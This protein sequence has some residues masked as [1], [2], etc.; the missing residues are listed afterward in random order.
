MNTTLSQIININN[1]VQM[2]N[3]NNRIRNQNINNINTNQLYKEKEQNIIIIYHPEK[4]SKDKKTHIKKKSQ[5]LNKKQ[6]I[7]LKENYLNKNKEEYIKILRKFKNEI[8]QEKNTIESID[9]QDKLFNQ[10]K[11]KLISILHKYSYRI[12]TTTNISEIKKEYQLFRNEYVD[13]LANYYID[14]ITA[15]HI[16]TET[17]IIILYSDNLKKIRNMMY[18]SIDNILTKEIS[19]NTYNNCN[20][21]NL[22]INQIKEKYILTC[23]YGYREIEIIKKTFNNEI[24][25]E[26]KKY[27][28]RKNIIDNLKYDP[29]IANSQII[30]DLENNILNEEYFYQIYSQLNTLTKIKCKFI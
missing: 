14:F 16:S 1:A 4:Y 26:F 3:L 21:Q 17:N 10:N 28:I 20:N 2:T 22:I 24:R 9:H 11:D 8:I 30:I 19:K 7:L 13:A 27:Q 29:N 25:I 23:L 18:K 6:K 15:S 12:T 5:E